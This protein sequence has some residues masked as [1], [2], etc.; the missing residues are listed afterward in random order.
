MR[1]T[2]LALGTGILGSLAMLLVLL[3]SDLIPLA[4][5]ILWVRRFRHLANGTFSIYLM[6]YP[7]MV[8]ATALGL[9][10]PHSLVL[11]V[12]TLTL[13]CLG[14][15]LIARPLDLFFFFIV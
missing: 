12:T 6:H 8:L 5:R 15:I 14:L 3:L 11:N 4:P 13:I 10:R 7:L 2:M 1:A 9:L